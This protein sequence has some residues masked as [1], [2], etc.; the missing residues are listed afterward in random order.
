MTSA[1]DS[2]DALTPQEHRAVAVQLF[3]QVWTMLEDKDRSVEADDRMLHAAH[4]SRYHWGQVGTAEQLA[5]GEWQCSRVYAVLGRGEPSLYHAQR[6]LAIAEGPELP[7]WLR[8]SAME[9]LARASA[10][11]GDETEARRW[12]T[13]AR[14]AAD[15]IED[16]EDREVVMGDLAT[17]PVGAP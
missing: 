5:V 15:A 11:A 16:P 4:A 8:A 12:A 3:N 9:G 2:D 10:V 7:D 6:A 1:I 13:A 14:S 17:L